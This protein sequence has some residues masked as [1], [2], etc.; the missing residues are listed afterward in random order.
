[1]QF[2]IVQ[3]NTNLSFVELIPMK[4]LLKI[5]IVTLLASY[6]VKL[7]TSII[8]L[9]SLFVMLGL[10]AGMFVVLYYILCW[11][12]KIEYK[13]IFVSYISPQKYNWLIKL[14]P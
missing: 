11:L 10:V 7:A 6:I 12:F 1:M 3:K 2:S 4:E 14:I 13:D 8:E 9:N 5:S